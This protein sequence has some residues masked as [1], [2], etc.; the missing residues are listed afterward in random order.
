MRHSLYCSCHRCNGELTPRA[1]QERQRNYA[2]GGPPRT[3]MVRPTL[4][5]PLVS[6]EDL[7]RLK[8]H[9][10]GRPLDPPS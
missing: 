3:R 8:E 6:E 2:N 7:A 9:F 4:T 1:V 5:A 10:Q